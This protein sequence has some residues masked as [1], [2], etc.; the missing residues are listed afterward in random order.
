VRARGAGLW[1]LLAAL[2]ISGAGAGAPRDA[3]QDDGWMI[4]V[5]GVAQDAGMPHLGC[6]ESRCV[7][8]RRGARRGE[9]VA[10]LGVVNRSLNRAYLFD[11]TPDFRAQAHRLNDGRPIDGIFLTHAHVG[12]YTGLMYLGKESI[13]AKGVP[14]FGSRRM[15]DYLSGNGPW[16]L[17]VKDAHIVPRLLEPDRPVALDGGLRVTAFAVPHRDEFTDTIGFLIQGPRAQ[18]LFIPDIDRWERWDRSI[19]DLA[20]RVDL[21]F[22]DGTFSSPGEVKGRRLE[23]IPHPMMSETREL[24]KGAASR[25]WFI[26]LNHTN[27]A[28]DGAADVVQ[29]GMEFPI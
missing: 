27:P 1:L 11:A 6:Q 20:D 28:L 25:L 12:H 17:L 16:S 5:L 21:A 23:D 15:I 2:G 8:A 13:A 9:K 24:L 22:L 7:D 18:A 29:E 3:R 19:R 10:S 14:V 26:H 4:V